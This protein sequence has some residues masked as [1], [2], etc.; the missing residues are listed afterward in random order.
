MMQLELNW[1]EGMAFEAK[2]GSNLVAMDAKTPIGRN[3]GAT[4]KE[5]VAAGLAGCTAMDVIA[6]MRKHKQ[7]VSHFS[8]KTDITTTEKGHPAV[9]TAAKMNFYLEGKVDPAKAVE[10]VHLS[11]T[12]YCGVSAMLSKAFP[13]TWEVFVNGESVGNGQAQF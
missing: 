10:A 5:L 13:I 1:K 2:A 4:P 8:V 9:F 11:Q 7:E 12:Q 3:T 6:L